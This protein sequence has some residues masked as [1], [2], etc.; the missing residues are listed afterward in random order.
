MKPLFWLNVV[1]HVNTRVKQIP[2][3]ANSR[4]EI[5]NHKILIRMMK[6]KSLHVNHV[7]S[8]ISSSN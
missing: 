7:E 6:K 2:S 8:Y 3:H 1:A 5:F 4:P